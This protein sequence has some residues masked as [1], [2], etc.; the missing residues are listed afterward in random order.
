MVCRS[1]GRSGTAAAT[2]VERGLPALNL[3]GGMQ[4]WKAASFPV[5]A[6]GGVRGE[7]V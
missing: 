2:L 3:A 7:V 5:V 1:G 4:A 6:D